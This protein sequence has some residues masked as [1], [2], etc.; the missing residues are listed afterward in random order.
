[1]DS[2]RNLYSSLQCSGAGTWLHAGQFT[3]LQSERTP[4]PKPLQ[5]QLSMSSS[6]AA[7]I[8]WAP[9]ALPWGCSAPSPPAPSQGVAQHSAAFAAPPHPAP[10]GC[11]GQQAGPGGPSAGGA[12]FSVYP[13]GAACEGLGGSCRRPGAL[14]LLLLLL[15]GGRESAEQHGV[16]AGSRARRRRSSLVPP[17]SS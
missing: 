6:C 12:D 5:L 4:I 17:A 1:M 9:E 3:H 13:H 2:Q 11:V 16:T 10:Q 14:L 8:T 15:T 7:K